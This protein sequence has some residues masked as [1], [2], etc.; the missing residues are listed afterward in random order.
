M[1]I[2]MD[3]DLD[4][5]S[6]P[7]PRPRVLHVAPTLTTTSI[8]IHNRTW[9]FKGEGQTAY[10]LPVIKLHVGRMW[11]EKGATWWVKDQWLTCSTSSKMVQVEAHAYLITSQQYVHIQH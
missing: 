2:D 6:H 8:C 7:Q 3:M 9:I 11:W 10:D 4:T 1:D 5:H